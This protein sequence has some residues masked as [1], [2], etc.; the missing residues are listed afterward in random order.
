M[1]IREDKEKPVEFTRRSVI[2][3]TSGPISLDETKRDNNE[4]VQINS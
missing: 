3:P 2:K 1:V 4:I